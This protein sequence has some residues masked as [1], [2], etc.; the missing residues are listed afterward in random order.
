MS[1]V[2]RGEESLE[3]GAGAAEIAGSGVGL[4]RTDGDV[5]LLRL[6]SA[7]AGIALLVLQPGQQSVELV[8]L[9]IQIGKSADDT[10]LAVQVV[11]LVKGSPVH[12]NGFVGA[13]LAGQGFGEGERDLG[14][15]RIDTHGPAESI[16]PLFRS[17]ELEAELGKKLVTFGIPRRG[18]QQ[19]S[20]SLDG[21]VGASQPCLELGDSHQVLGAI[22][23]VDVGKPAQS[24]GGIAQVAGRFAHPCYQ[25]P[26][27]DRPRLDLD[28]FFGRANGIGQLTVCFEV[29][30]QDVPLL[31]R[32]FLGALK[33]FGERCDPHGHA[34]G[35]LVVLDACFE[36]GVSLL[37]FLGKLPRRGQLGLRLVIVLEPVQIVGELEVVV[38]VVSFKLDRL[39][40][41]SDRLFQIAKAREDLG[42]A[43]QVFGV[44]VGA[45]GDLCPGG[46]G[47]FGPLE[48]MQVFT[49]IFVVLRIGGR[50]RGGFPVEGEGIVG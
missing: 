44:L 34:V 20:T 27:G 31:G 21:G 10:Q 47:F 7:R 37:V 19:V 23:P 5:T 24:V 12:L 29:T 35:G 38:E 13:I 49:D 3:L 32:R 2:L 8:A 28:R 1:R 30:G 22:A 46:L 16:E 17:A 6:T 9:E 48:V 50:E 41:R 40:K 11:G 15:V 33:L 14:I 45:V 39:G 26:C 25:S 18:R 42:Q 43:C 4:G 36:D